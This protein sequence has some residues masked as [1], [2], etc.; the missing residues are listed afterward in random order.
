MRLHQRL[1]NNS[2]G[3]LATRYGEQIPLSGTQQN[4]LLARQEELLA[5]ANKVIILELD[6]RVTR[7]ARSITRYGER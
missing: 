7:E 4:S 6:L 2:R 3:E 1:M 5:T